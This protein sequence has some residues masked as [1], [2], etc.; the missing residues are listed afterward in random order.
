[1]KN[2]LLAAVAAATAL[3]AAALEASAADAVKRPYYM[4]YTLM[5]RVFHDNGQTFFAVQNR[6]A[7]RI[8]KGHAIE[9]GYHIATERRP[10]T[11]TVTAPA[12]LAR[13][14][15]IKFPGVNHARGCSATTRLHARA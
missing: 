13:Y 2:V 8:P 7:L 4:S 9:I 5:C 15:M 12:D 10:I 6:T 3:S 1:M 14:G 11:T